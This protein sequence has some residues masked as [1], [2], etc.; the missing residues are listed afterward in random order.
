L[1]DTE[2]PVAALAHVASLSE[3]AV[4]HY[5]AGIA[6]GE[7]P[8]DHLALKKNLSYGPLHAKKDFHN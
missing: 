1:V 5:A 6:N 3:F 8:L 7:L 4:R 2:R